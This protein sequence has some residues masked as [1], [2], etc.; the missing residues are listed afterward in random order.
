[1]LLHGDPMA[2]TDARRQFRLSL[3]IGK[4]EV[5]LCGRPLGG[6]VLLRAGILSRNH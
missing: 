3:V 4:G 1:M 2:G 5:S 6:G